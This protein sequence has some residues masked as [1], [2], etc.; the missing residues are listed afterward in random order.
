MR[1]NLINTTKQANETVN[2]DFNETDL[3]PLVELV[4]TAAIAQLNE[5]RD[6]LLDK[7]AYTEPEA[8]ALLSIRPHVLRDARLRGEIGAC[9]LGRRVLYPRDE[10]LKFLQAQRGV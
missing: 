10:L 4:V 8:A 1:P 5:Q 6:Q 9:R 7:L 2:I 3:K